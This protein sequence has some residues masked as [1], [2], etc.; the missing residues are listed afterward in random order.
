MAK[1]EAKDICDITPIGLGV[2]PDLYSKVA[3]TAR[4]F[5]VDVAC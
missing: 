2:I 4:R 5:R 3:S 1:N